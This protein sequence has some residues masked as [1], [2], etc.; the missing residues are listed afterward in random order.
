MRCRF[1]PWVGRSPGERNG[2]PTAVFLPGKSHGQRSLV[3]YSLWG[4][5]E[6]DM[7]E[8][9][10][11]HACMIKCYIKKFK[12]H[13]VVALSYT[14]GKKLWNETR[15]RA[16]QMDHTDLYKY[17]HTHSDIKHIPD[18][19]SDTFSFPGDLG[20][21]IHMTSSFFKGLHY[22]LYSPASGQRLPLFPKPSRALQYINKHHSSITEISLN[23]VLIFDLSFTNFMTLSKCM[24]SL[25]HSFPHF[26]D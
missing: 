6:S 20:S 8:Q 26:N 12:L 21:R 18:T 25:G 7:T 9:V 4:C 22:W 14:T 24:P 16:V 3:G 13:Y 10:S 23:Q 17:T 15:L 19:I 11:M 1:D 2:T 5:K